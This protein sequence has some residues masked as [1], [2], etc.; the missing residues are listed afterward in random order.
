MPFIQKT[1]RITIAGIIFIFASFTFAL[2]V[3]DN[4]GPCRNIKGKHFSVY[5]APQ[6]DLSGLAE[7]LNIGSSDKI[8]SQCSINKGGSADS[9]FTQALD[10]L[11]MRICDILDMHLYSFNGTIKVCRDY[12][13]LKQV[14]KSI[15]NEEL[16][17]LSFYV[18]DLN[19][20]YTS[21]ENFKSEIIGHEMAHTL[22]SH[23][24][25]VPP[26]EKIQE[27]LAGYAEYQLHK[28]NLESHTTLAS[29]EKSQ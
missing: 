27:L 23:Y 25:V 29:V 2:A 28:S 12:K 9:D 17:S 16:R 5:C 7:R 18:Y 26:S 1:G 21:A 10:A 24:F 20:I 15:F 19:T 13:H 4:F 14:Y 8:L 11:F 6:Q 22:I 3:E